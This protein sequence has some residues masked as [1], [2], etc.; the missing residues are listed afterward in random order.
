MM[1]TPRELAEE[2]ERATTAHLEHLDALTEEVENDPEALAAWQK[3]TDEGLT[4]V[5]Y[6]LNHLDSIAGVDG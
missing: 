1:H 3:K 5:L 2:L 4:H 6:L